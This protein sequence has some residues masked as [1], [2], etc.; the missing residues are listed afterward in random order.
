MTRAPRE[1]KSRTYSK[2]LTSWSLA[3]IFIL[4]ALGREAEVIYAVSSAAVAHLL[5]YMGTGHLDLRSIL[6]SELLKLR[7]RGPDA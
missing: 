5:L 1:Q 4:A 7:K 6:T 2:R 3:G